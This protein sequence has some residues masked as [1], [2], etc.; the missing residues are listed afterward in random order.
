MQ[1]GT[2]NKSALL[3]PMV[4]CEILSILGSLNQ[5]KHEGSLIL[6]ITLYNLQ[7]R[8]YNNSVSDSQVIFYN[9]TSF[10]GFHA[11]FSHYDVSILNSR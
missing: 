2:G 4:K 6:S 3:V 9:G 1:K 5:Y 10:L 7:D 11:L 8:N